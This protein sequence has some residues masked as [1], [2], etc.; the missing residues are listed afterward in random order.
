[1]GQNH[2]GD[3]KI[4]K[5]IVDEAYFA[6]CSAVK[7]AKR[8]LTCELTD[9]A[10]KRIY[11]N[12]NAFGKTYGEHRE[13]LELSLADHRMI[14]KWC[15]N[16]GMDYFLSV[17]DIPSLEFAL[18]LGCPV[19]KLPSKEINNIPLLNEIGGYDIPVIWSIGMCT[20]A[21]FRKAMAILPRDSTIVV[22]TSMYPTYIDNINLNRLNWLKFTERKLG[23]SCHNP[24]PLL[25]I[26]AA[27]MGARYVEYHITLDREMKGSDHICSL[28]PEEFR[29][30][31]DGI[32]TIRIALGSSQIPKVLPDYLKSTVKK[33]KKTKCEDGVYRV[34]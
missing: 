16:R 18:E 10:Y 22:T 6:G 4:A 28:E 27:S 32:K 7:S 24:E 31:V 9:E 13:L 15:N 2:N 1:M 25:G 34:V 30:L 17:C 12:P 33:L 3:L 14:K 23:F 21:E 29:Y 8:D 26:V 20:E 11:D 5:E 19:I